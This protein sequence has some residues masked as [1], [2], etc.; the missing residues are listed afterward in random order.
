MPAPRERAKH[1]SSLLGIDRLSENPTVDEHHGVGGDHGTIARRRQH[2]VRL[3]LG[4]TTNVL[5][6]QLARMHRFVGA[7]GPGADPLSVPPRVA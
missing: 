5:F 2:R 4:D 3:G 1:R 6:R 7:G